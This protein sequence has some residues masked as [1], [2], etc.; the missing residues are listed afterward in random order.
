MSGQLFKI[1]EKY[2]MKRDNSGFSKQKVFR[3]IYARFSIVN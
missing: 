2:H 1:D 3:S